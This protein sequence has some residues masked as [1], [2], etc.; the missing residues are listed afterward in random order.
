M[1]RGP[2]PEH[3]RKYLRVYSESSFSEDFKYVIKNSMSLT[4]K[5]THELRIQ[6]Y[7]KKKTLLYIAM[8]LCICLKIKF[9]IFA[10]LSFF[11]LIK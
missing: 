9:S 3:H 10:L 7:L 2:I 11:K 5:Q 8:L 4:D 6:D 1:V